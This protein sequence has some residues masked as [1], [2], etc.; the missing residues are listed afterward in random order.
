MN[1]ISSFKIYS[2]IY[3]IT[4][5]VSLLFIDNNESIIE[6]ILKILTI[7]LT[8]FLYLAYTTKINYW[9]LLLL[10]FCIVA[11]ALL[12]FDQDFLKGGILLLMFTRVIYLIILRKTILTIKLKVILP[13][14]IPGCFAFFIMSYLLYSFVENMLLS[15]FMICLL[16]LIVIGVSFYQYLYNMT[17]DNLYFMLGIFLITIADFIIAFNKFLDYQLYYVVLY[18]VMYY[19]ARYLICIAMIKEKR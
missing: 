3:F 19:V 17:K 14:I 12:I 5:I 10:M 13:Y 11:D 18:T 4:C 7:V 2:V 6:M 9:Y 8:S 15:I 1:H 16:N